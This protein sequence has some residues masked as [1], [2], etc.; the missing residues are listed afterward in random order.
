MRTLLF[1]TLVLLATAGVAAAHASMTPTITPANKNTKVTFGIGHGCDGEDTYKVVV[2]IPAGIA[3]ANVKAMSSPEYGYAEITEDV[4]G[5]HVTW[6]KD[7]ADI[8][9]SDSAYYELTVR[10]RTPNAA[11]TRLQWDVHQYCKNP[12]GGEDL[13]HHWDDPPGGGP[14]NAPMMTLQPSTKAGGWNEFTLAGAVAVADFPTYFVDALIVWRGTSAFSANPVIAAMIAATPG[15]T[16]LTD[17][18]IDDVIL[19]KY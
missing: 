12:A 8:L 15:V 13:A 3:L 10:V 19:V 5:I 17:L 4:D 16:A 1:T 14:D 18:A 7:D 11:F 2:D 9:A 6:T